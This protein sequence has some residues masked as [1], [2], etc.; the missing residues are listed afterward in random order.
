MKLPLWIVILIYLSCWPAAVFSQP[1]YSAEAN[2]VR[3]VL[4][5]EKC[6]MKEV[7]NL[8]YKAIWT[9]KG[10]EFQGCWAARPDEGLVVGYFSDKTVALM[11][12][13]AFKKVLEI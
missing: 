8:P 3:I 1:L 11:P 13:Y 9:E 5:D 2:G 7:A 4:T 12:V 6:E 10:Q